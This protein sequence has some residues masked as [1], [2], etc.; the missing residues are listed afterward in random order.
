MKFI[1]IRSLEHESPLAGLQPA[2]TRYESETE[3]RRTVDE[4]D[5]TGLRYINPSLVLP[6]EEPWLPKQGQDPQEEGIRSVE[7]GRGEGSDGGAQGE[8]NV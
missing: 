5:E 1:A 8:Q 3:G 2:E 4:S 7:G 6:L